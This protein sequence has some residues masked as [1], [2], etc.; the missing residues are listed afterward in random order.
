[1]LHSIR[2]Y[3][4]I[5]R[6][7]SGI[8]HARRAPNPLRVRTASSVCGGS[9][10]AALRATIVRLRMGT[11]TGDPR[12]RRLP[13]QQ[14]AI[15]SVP[16]VLRAV[17]VE[18][19]A[20]K[21]NLISIISQI[22]SITRKFDRN[23]MGISRKNYSQKKEHNLLKPNLSSVC[24]KSQNCASVESSFSLFPFVLRK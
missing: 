4:S 16:E 5:M 14:V 1:M 15:P 22:M 6:N 21:T 7:F 24:K 3:A 13:L 8:I 9:A 23:N 17:R 10:T 12:T 18:Q 19:E 2:H 20:H 11:S